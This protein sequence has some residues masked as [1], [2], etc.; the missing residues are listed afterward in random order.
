[1]G[2]VILVVVL[3]LAAAIAESVFLWR[4][5]LKRE[6]G[7]SLFVW[8]VALVYAALVA[9]PLGEKFSLARL[10][11]GTLDRIFGLFS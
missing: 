4:N 5:K 2:V 11:I 10:V 6:A 7:F 1:M 9:S 8:V 3:I